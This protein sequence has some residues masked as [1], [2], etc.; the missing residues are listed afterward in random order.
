MQVII[1]VLAIISAMIDTMILLM[2]VKIISDNIISY[3]VV[4]V[5]IFTSSLEIILYV[6]T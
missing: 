5:G 1:L 6:I 3:S 4:F 2:V